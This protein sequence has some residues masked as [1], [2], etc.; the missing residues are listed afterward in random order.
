MM[1]MEKIK[2]RKTNQANEKQ[3]NNAKPFD[4]EAAVHEADMVH[5]VYVKELDA[6]VKLKALTFKDLVD[7]AVLKPGADQVCG[8][9]Y[10]SMSKAT[11]GLTVE[12]V[13]AL[14]VGHIAALAQVVI[15]ISGLSDW[16]EIQWATPPRP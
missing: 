11:P 12:A 14:K 10:R 13:H 15:K 7:L 1:V 5:Q 3:P 9:I 16:K 6:V 4:P 8:M 2:M